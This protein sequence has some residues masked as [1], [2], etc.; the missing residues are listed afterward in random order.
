MPDTPPP[1]IQE[2]GKRT[3]ERI[4]AAA[5]SLLDERLFEEATIG[6]IAERAGVSV[7]TIYTRFRTKEALLP[8]LFER[9]HAAVGRRFAD[10][11]RDLAEAADLDAGVKTLVAFAVDYHLCHRGL[12]RALTMY[13]RGKG[14]ELPAEAWSARQAQ[15]RAVAEHLL[16]VA[17][18]RRTPRLL[19]ETEFALAALNSICR[20]QLLFDDVTPLRGSRRG[21]RAF[22]RRLTALIL[23]DL[24]SVLT[25]T[26]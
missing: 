24:S 11:D 2:R 9:H 14:G 13:V 17:G 12:L 10:L 6:A 3:L 16:R 5:E 8:V 1:P 7:G 4:L 20:E 26:P 15:Y 19:E 22:E 18:R 25:P 23:H 21:R